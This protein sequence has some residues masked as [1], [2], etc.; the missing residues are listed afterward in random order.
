MSLL[1]GVL[2]RPRKGKPYSRMPEGLDAGGQWHWERSCYL[3]RQFATVDEALRCAIAVAVQKGDA[4]QSVYRCEFCEAYHL[5]H[6][7]KRR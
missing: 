5:G 2:E 6:G 7:D 3:K 1:R 4:G